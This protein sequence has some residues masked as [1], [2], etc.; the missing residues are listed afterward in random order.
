MTYQFGY[1]GTPAYLRTYIDTDRNP[2]TGFAQGGIGADYLLENATL[3]RHNGS[4]WSWT[5]VKTVT[6]SSA[7]APP[8][9]RSPARTSV[10]APPP[11]TPT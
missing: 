7:W 3:Y 11:T 9:G 8:A 2:A 6:F 1:T 4:G 10:R 5:T